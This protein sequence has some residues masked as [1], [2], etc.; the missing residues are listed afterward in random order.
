MGR[1]AQAFVMACLLAACSGNKP[2]KPSDT[3]QDPTPAIQ[4]TPKMVEAETKIVMLGDSL[5]AGYGLL[6]GEA[7]PDV[8]ER[9]LRDTGHDVAIINAGVSGDTTGMGLAR[10]NWSVT[11]NEPDMLIIA[12]GANDFLGGYPSELARSNLAAI[13]ERA[14]SEDISVILAG[15]EPR[16]PDTSDVLEAE[17]AKLYPELAEEYDIPLYS[18][19]MNGVW[20]TPELLLPDGLHPNREGVKKMAEGLVDFLEVEL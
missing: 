7:V 16:W 12:L 8:I 11:S 18:G 5:T 10:F 19:F 4:E 20:N 9:Q 17:Y 6:E 3:V 1:I 15:L 2:D 14:Q 13:I